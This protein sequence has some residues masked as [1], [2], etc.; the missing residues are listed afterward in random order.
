[1]KNILCYAIVILSLSSC[2]SRI[3]KN[4]YMFELSEYQSLQEGI[5]SKDTVLKMMGSPTIISNLDDDESWIYYEQ[6]SRSLLFFLPDIVSRNIITINFDNSGTIKKLE[7]F[8]LDSE[9]KMNF[10]SNYTKVDSRKTGFFK[11][12]F[13]N[14]G[15]VKPQ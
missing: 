15:Q 2:I 8:D 1:M 11:S 3:D 7:K 14:I 13:S 12:I 4:G 5:S 6:D 10:V 9:Q